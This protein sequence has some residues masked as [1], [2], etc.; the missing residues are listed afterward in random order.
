MGQ[1][2]RI[3]EVF[4]LFILCSPAFPT[5]ELKA[6]ESTQHLHSAGRHL[7][8]SEL[9]YSL[10]VPLAIKSGQDSQRA[11]HEALSAPRPPV[12]LGFL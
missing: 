3:A 9:S 8:F 10:M 5:V 4:W 12:R 1:G 6:E 11:W 2:S 7:G